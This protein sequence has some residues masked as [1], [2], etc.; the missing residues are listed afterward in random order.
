MYTRP[1]VRGKPVCTHLAWYCYSALAYIHERGVVH[2]DIKPENIILCPPKAPRPVV[3]LLDFGLSK[4]IGSDSL[5][6][7]F[8]GT[9]QYVCVVRLFSTSV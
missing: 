6:T 3:K 1:A 8:V 4:M 9:P 7:T 5:A 2:R